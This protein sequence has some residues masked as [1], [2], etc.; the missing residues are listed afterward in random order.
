MNTVPRP[1]HNY[2]EGWHTWRPDASRGAFCVV[3]D[4][5]QR[6]WCWYDA[7]EQRPYG[8]FTSSREAFREARAQANKFVSPA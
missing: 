7:A 6:A 8:P 2:Y 4:E 1:T 3:W 5:R